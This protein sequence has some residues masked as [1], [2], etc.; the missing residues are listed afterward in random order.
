GRFL[1][2]PGRFR[3]L[4]ECWHDL[5]PLSA[6]PCADTRPTLRYPVADRDAR[7]ILEKAFDVFVYL[8]FRT[9]IDDAAAQ[10]LH[11]ASELSG[12]F[13]VRRPYW[14]RSL[15]HRRLLVPAAR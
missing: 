10:L 11:L 1:W 15:E 7:A 3:E 9:G 14:L 4:A 2:A 6:N 8:F 13:L 12:K 5:D